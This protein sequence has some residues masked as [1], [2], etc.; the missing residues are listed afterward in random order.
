MANE[1]GIGVGVIETVDESTRVNTK[2]AFDLVYWVGKFVAS[3]VPSDYSINGSETNGVVLLN[4]GLEQIGVRFTDEYDL[5]LQLLEP[6]KITAD[7]ALRTRGAVLVSEGRI[8]ISAGLDTVIDIVNGRH[9]MYKCVYSPQAPSTC[10][11][12]WLYGAYVPGV[13]YR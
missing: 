6:N 4:W 13:M 10:R 3:G 5:A 11:N 2:S 1:L 8:S 7:K 12:R 9:F